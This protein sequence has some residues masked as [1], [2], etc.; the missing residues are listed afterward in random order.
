MTYAEKNFLSDLEKF[1]A[2]F[3]ERN[4][5]MDIPYKCMMPSRVPKNTTIM[6]TLAKD[7]IVYVILC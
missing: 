6:D 7:L 5:S 1:E 3:N 4:K 2:E